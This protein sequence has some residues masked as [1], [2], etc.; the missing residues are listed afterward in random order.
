MRV[1]IDATNSAVRDFYTLVIET[2]HGK[3]AVPFRVIPDGPVVDMWTP[4]EPEEGDLYYM[5]L[6]GANLRGATVQTSEPGVSVFAVDSSQE[7]ALTG[8]LEVSPGTP[9][10]RVD[11]IVHGRNPLAAPA[12]ISIQ[13]RAKGTR[14]IK[15]LNLRN[16]PAAGG[17]GG[18]ATTGP[19]IYVQE[20]AQ[21]DPL[22][23]AAGFEFCL[24]F[25]RHRTFQYQRTF[26]FDPNT[27]RV[28]RGALEAAEIGDRIPLRL[29]VYSI[30]HSFTLQL[31]I[32]CDL[33]TGAHLCVHSTLGFEVLGRWGQV[34]TFTACVLVDLEVGGAFVSVTTGGI[35]GSASFH[36][37]TGEGTGGADC[38]ELVDQAP[39]PIEGVFEGE[40]EI[41]DCCRQDVSIDAS[42][43]GHT[44]EG[45]FF[46]RS[47]AL[48]SSP[49]T[50][51]P[52]TCPATCPA[53]VTLG[54]Q[55]LYPPE[56]G[57]KL[58][59]SIKNDS[60]S[61][62]CTYDWSLGQVPQTGDPAVGASP[63]T[64][65][66]VL[67]PGAKK[68]LEFTLQIPEQNEAAV[69][70]KLRL[71]ATD[72]AT[73]DVFNGE[74]AVCVIPQ[75]E[76]SAFIS[77]QSTLTDV[78][79]FLAAVGP[80]ETDYDGRSVNELWVS[81]YDHCRIEGLT[82][83]PP[84]APFSNGNSWTVGQYGIENQYSDDIIGGRTNLWNAY[85]PYYGPF[86]T[87]TMGG[88]QRMSMNC[89]FEPRADYHDNENSVSV[90]FL[91]PSS[92]GVRVCRGG[93]SSL[94]CGEHDRP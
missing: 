49:V 51:V 90:F 35:F 14:A 89:S 23:A 66:T 63:L 15:Q 38:V 61:E 43:T 69:D 39:G 88:V 80:T 13:V 11:I 92:G 24:R 18:S 5:F 31:A 42:V 75:R 48:A 52:A 40:I 22:N 33:R 1:E 71:A 68:D 79:V 81:T 3:E 26:V 94:A 72:T 78:G 7:E 41:V 4:S 2:P 45:F 62:T 8:F 58:T 12:V 87:C 29:E 73:G 46:E 83:L 60:T 54:N 57:K 56:P 86:E 30:F 6:V 47:V 70:A 85:R 84:F 16:E 27:G 74:G 91:D 21:R 76:A 37:G 36:I 59:G 9:I 77:W 17:G 32:G 44:F 55:S 82:P 67:A 10:D 65:T 20:L 93:V 25:F 50:S 53:E 64:G 34:V 19:A 28:I